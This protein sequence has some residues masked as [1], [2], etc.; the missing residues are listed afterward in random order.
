LRCSHLSRIM[1]VIIF[2]IKAEEKGEK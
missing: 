2:I 1:I